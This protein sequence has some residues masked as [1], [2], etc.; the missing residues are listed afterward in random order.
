MV[1]LPKNGYNYARKYIE[2]S[3]FNFEE[4]DINNYLNGTEH[5]GKVFAVKSN[6][7]I[8]VNN[9][10]CNFNMPEISNILKITHKNSTNNKYEFNFKI[11]ISKKACIDAVYLYIH[12]ED[13]I[14]KT[15]GQENTNKSRDK[16]RA[17]SGFL[18]RVGKKEITDDSLPDFISET[19]MTLNVNEF[20]YSL[21]LNTKKNS[22]DYLKFLEFFGEASVNFGKYSPA[23][24]IYK[25]DGNYKI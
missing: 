11:N 24:T 13:C 4:G 14:E 18:I 8:S 3:G 2:K 17:K 9:P 21:L 5:E 22:K 25:Y 15:N 10:Q 6:E 16:Q 19:N 12:C 7:S 1:F 20:K 23:D